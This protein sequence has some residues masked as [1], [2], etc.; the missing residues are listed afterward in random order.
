[1]MAI[2]Q[3]RQNCNQAIELWLVD[4]RRIGTI[5]IVAPAASSAARSGGSAGT[6]TW[7]VKP[8]GAN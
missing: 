7:H 4:I 5:V 1:M 2:G 3:Y 8:L 6:T